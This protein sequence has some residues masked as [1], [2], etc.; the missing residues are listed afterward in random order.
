MGL[1]VGQHAHTDEDL[2][3]LHR[4]RDRNA[5]RNDDTYRLVQKPANDR[6]IARLEALTAKEQTS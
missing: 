1:H 5:W 6:H 4:W 3:E 2:A